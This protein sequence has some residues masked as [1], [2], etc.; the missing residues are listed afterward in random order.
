LPADLRH[1]VYKVCYFLSQVGA[2][3]I[4][5]ILRQDAFLA[6]FRARS[7]ATWTIAGPFIRRERERNPHLGPEFL[8]IVEALAAKSAMFGPEIGQ[9]IIKRWLAK[10]IRMR[11]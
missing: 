4:L 11:T 5:D 9:G 3:L 2:M 6:N 10:P 1:D 8:A 7:V